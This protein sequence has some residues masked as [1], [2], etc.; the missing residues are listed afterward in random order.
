MILQYL[1]DLK[2]A[3]HKGGYLLLSGLLTTDQK[4]IVDAC[5]GQELQLIKQVEKNNWISLLFVNQD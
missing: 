5:V 4:D 2:K 1:P 3:V